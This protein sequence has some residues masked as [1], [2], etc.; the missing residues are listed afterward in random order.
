M[1]PPRRSWIPRADWRQGFLSRSPMP[2]R[3]VSNEEFPPHPPTPAQRHVLGD[4]SHGVWR[5]ERPAAGRLQLLNRT[6]RG[7]RD[8]APARTIG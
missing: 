2:T 7:G 6:L 1:T 8:E 5:L 3:I 4:E